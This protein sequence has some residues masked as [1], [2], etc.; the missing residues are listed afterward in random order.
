M[1]VPTEVTADLIEVVECVDDSQEP[2]LSANHKCRLF[3]SVSLVFDKRWTGTTSIKAESC[4]DTDDDAEVLTQLFTEAL[5]K[6]EGMDATVTKTEGGCMITD[7]KV[8]AAVDPAHL[9]PL[10]VSCLWLEP[11]VPESRRNDQFIV[12]ADAER[13]IMQ[14]RQQ[15]KM[16]VMDQNYV[17]KRI[18]ASKKDGSS[19]AD[20]KGGRMFQTIEALK[21][22]IQS[23]IDDVASVSCLVCCLQCGRVVKVVRGLM[24][25]GAEMLSAVQIQ[26]Q[27]EIQKKAKADEEAAAKKRK[28]EEEKAAKME[29][30]F[31]EVE[32]EI[33]KI[34]IEEI[35][36]K[37]EK[38]QGAANKQKR[39]KL[40]RRIKELLASVGLTALPPKEADE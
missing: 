5:S 6:T 28:E 10:S 40:Q 14:L 7:P 4:G 39:K 24:P 30:M 16:F 15:V 37:L 12:L 2:H 31:S 32:V 3:D 23:Q 9:L 20:S 21:K 27:I 22:I 18:K 25:K 17:L 8:T 35:E 38:L 19:A 1:S 26:K 33:V 13:V 11:E 29:S 36:E 34:K